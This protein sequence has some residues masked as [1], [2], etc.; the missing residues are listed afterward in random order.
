MPPPIEAL[1]VVVR[2]PV[3]QADLPA[4][5]GPARRQELL[6]AE[7][8]RD[9]DRV[10]L[11]EHA[12]LHLVLNSPKQGGR[13]ELLGDRGGQMDFAIEG[14]ARS[15]MVLARAFSGRVESLRIPKR[16]VF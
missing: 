1:I 2:Q 3:L 16:R 5:V 10:R 9:D 13:Q 6:V 4:L 12:E 14:F 15:L 8:M 11:V 7:E